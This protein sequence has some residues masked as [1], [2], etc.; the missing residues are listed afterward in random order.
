M[1][2]LFVIAY[3]FV[4]SFSGQNCKQSPSPLI[5]CDRLRRPCR[6]GR[7]CLARPVLVFTITW[8]DARHAP[9]PKLGSLMAFLGHTLGIIG[10][11]AFSE[12]FLWNVA[13]TFIQRAVKQGAHFRLPMFVR[14]VAAGAR[15][16]GEDRPSSCRSRLR[17][18]PMYSSG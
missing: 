3:V 10:M 8:T 14:D 9:F 16:Y 4:K 18:F 7:S 11:I 5:R 6:V 15:V 1:A 12:F 13:I 2:I 17:I